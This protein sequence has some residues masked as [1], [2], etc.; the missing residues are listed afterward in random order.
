MAD[1]SNPQ[2]HQFDSFHFWKEPLLPIPMVVFFFV[3]KFISFFMARLRSV[4]SRGILASWRLHGI[5]STRWPIGSR[6]SICK[7]HLEMGI[8]E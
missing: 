2:L 4:E 1:G 5:Q 8:V 7:M 6:T 3:V